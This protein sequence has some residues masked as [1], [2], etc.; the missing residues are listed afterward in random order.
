MALR[1]PGPKGHFLTGSI[2]EFTGDT[3]AF[4]L[5]TRK[6]GDLTSFRFGPFT[7]YVVSSPEFAHQ[8]LVTDAAKYIKS[9]SLK[10]VMFPILGNGLFTND[11]DFWKRQR[12]LVQP[13]F[14]TRRIGAYAKV[15]VEHA[16]AL[17]TRWHDGQVYDIDH[18]MAHLTM[19]IVSKTLF[20]AD[21]SG[22]S[23]EIS[24]LVTDV[25][26]GAN[27]RLDRLFNLPYLRQRRRTAS[28]CARWRG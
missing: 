22:E 21:V 12:K 10:S 18:E 4:L 1:P 9:R 20:D 17:M 24:D 11:G 28:F 3:L 25:L 8:V 19:G 5:D 14:H 26:E 2:P 13:A 6:Y 15:M 7:G 23:S 27:T 16:Q